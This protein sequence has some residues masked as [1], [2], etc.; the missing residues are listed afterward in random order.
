MHEPSLCILSVCMCCCHGYQLAADAGESVAM[1]DDEK[2]RISDLLADLDTV[3]EVTVEEDMSV[4]V[5]ICCKCYLD[6]VEEVIV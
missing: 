2:K 1:T 6:A 4:Y 3:P 5:S